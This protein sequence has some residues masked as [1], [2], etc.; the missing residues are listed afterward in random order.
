MEQPEAPWAPKGTEELLDVI[1]T[2]DYGVSDDRSSMFATPAIKAY[3]DELRKANAQSWSQLVAANNAYERV[4]ENESGGNRK[5][6]NMSKAALAAAEAE[7]VRMA[8]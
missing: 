8:K 5:R 4:N 7:R 6:R 3:N 2:M 1:A